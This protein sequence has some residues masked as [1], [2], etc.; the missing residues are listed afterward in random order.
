MNINV[1]SYFP[2]LEC[3]NNDGVAG[4]GTGIDQGT[5]THYNEICNPDGSCTGTQYPSI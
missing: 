3:N 1:I 2:H 5:C 4:S